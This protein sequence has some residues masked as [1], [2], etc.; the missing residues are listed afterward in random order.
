MIDNNKMNKFTFEIHKI[1]FNYISNKNQL[2]I[3][4]IIQVVSNK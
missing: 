4:E 2:I 3:Y 1:K